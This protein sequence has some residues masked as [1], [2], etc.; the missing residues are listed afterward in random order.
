MRCLRWTRATAASNGAVDLNPYFST[1]PRSKM[2]S[3]MH[4]RSPLHLLTHAMQIGVALPFAVAALGFSSFSA[5]ADVV[6]EWNVRDGEFIAASGLPTPPAV[7]VM[8]IAHTAAFEAANAITKR[9]PAVALT[10]VEA[11][12]H[13]SVD[14]A[15]AAAHRVALTR[16]LPAQQSAI[17]SAY[18]AALGRIADGPAKDAGAAVGERAALA[19]LALRADD[20]AGEPPVYRPHTTADV[21]V[22]TTLPAVAQWPKRKPWLMTSAA[23]FRPGPPPAL[24]SERWARDYNEIK[25]MG[26]QRSTARSTEQTAI[27]RFWEATL[28]PIYHGVVR[29]VAEQPGRDV[30]RNA[31]LFAAVTQA[32]DDAVIAVFDAKYHHNF[33]RPIT[34]IRNGDIDGNDATER[35]ATWTPFIDTPMHPEYPCAHCIQAAVT[36]TVLQAEIGA[37]KEAPLSTTS[38]TANGATRR[39]PSVDALV[40]EVGNARVY[41]GVHYRFSTEVGIEMGRRIGALAVQRFLGD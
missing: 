29:S 28:P 33:W 24:Q 14:A 8:A 11:T 19:V 38:P 30:V 15:I 35:D 32:T 23:Q 36:G 1:D 6:T 20:G 21:Y 31:R 40:Q 16:L 13:A 5:R 12:P 41:D 3:A 37:G 34:A 17:D 22:P 7:R 39:W 2:E 10:R 27:A 4:T 25:A 18:Q 26:G 9:Y